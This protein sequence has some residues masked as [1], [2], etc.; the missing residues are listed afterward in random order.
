MY[1]EG[2]QPGEDA[3]NTP[4]RIPCLRVDCMRRDQHIAITAT[5]NVRTI[6]HGQA[7]SRVGLESTVWSEHKNGGR[8]HRVLGRELE[9]AVIDSAC[10]ER[11][12][13]R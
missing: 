12:R 5:R 11:N 7:K 9:L 6:R 3:S 13:V 4:Q 10:V 2:E 8:L 1:H